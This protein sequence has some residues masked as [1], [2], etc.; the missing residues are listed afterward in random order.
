MYERTFPTLFLHSSD[1]V[2]DL[3]EHTV[4]KAMND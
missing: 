2:G 4:P 3:L 1:G